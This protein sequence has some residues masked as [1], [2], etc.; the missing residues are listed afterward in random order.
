MAS[1][2]MQDCIPLCEIGYAGCGMSV[3]R[4]HTVDAYTRDLSG[5]L[6]IAGHLGASPHGRI[7]TLAARDFRAWLAR[8]SND[9]L[10]GHQQRARCPF[11]AASSFG[12]SATIGRVTMLS[13]FTPKQPH[14]VPNR[15][16]K[17]MPR[18]R[19]TTSGFWLASPDRRSRYRCHDLTLW[20]RSADFRSARPDPCASPIRRF[21]PRPR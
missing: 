10:S 5:F 7:E 2:E 18:R 15:S 3:G 17:R 4:P 1:Q 9:G 6:F 20:L 13:A 21:D 11:Y 8:R 19:S 16:T 14:A 12:S